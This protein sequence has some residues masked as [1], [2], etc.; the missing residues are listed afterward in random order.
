VP[1]CSYSAI[2]SAA[3]M[4]KIELSTEDESSFSCAIP[5][6]DGNP[7]EVFKLTMTRKELEDLSI[8]LLERTMVPV[9]KVLDEAGMKKSEIDELV[10]VGGSSRIPWVRAKLEEMFEKEPNDHIDPDVAVA[11]GCTTIAH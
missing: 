9:L 4:V 5:D 1:V 2:R 7:G 3:E 8:D 6:E 10:M 11:Y